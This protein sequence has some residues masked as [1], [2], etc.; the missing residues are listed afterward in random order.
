MMTT[1]IINS[2]YMQKKEDIQSAKPSSQIAIK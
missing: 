2:S 1:N